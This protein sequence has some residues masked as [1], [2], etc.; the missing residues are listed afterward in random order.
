MQIDLTL[1]ETGLQIDSFRLSNF[2][3]VLEGSGM[4]MEGP[5]LADWM[6]GEESWDTGQMELD[7]SLQ[8]PSLTWRLGGNPFRITGRIDLAG[9]DYPTFSFFLNARD[10]LLLRNEEANAR[11][12]LELTFKG[13]LPQMSLSGHITLTEGQILSRLRFLEAWIDPETRLSGPAIPLFSI[14]DPWLKDMTFDVRI[15]SYRPFKVRNNVLRSDMRPSLIL[16]GTGALPT[17]SGQIYLE[18]SVLF[19]PSSRILIHSGVIEFPKENPDQAYLDLQ[20]RTTMYGYDTTIAI[21][22]PHQD[23][24]ITVSSTP[25]LS[26]DEILLMLFTGLP[27]PRISARNSPGHPG[28]RVAVYVVRD[29]MSRWLRDTSPSQE[30]PFL[31]RF[32]LSIGGKVTRSGD[33]TIDA[34]YLLKEGLLRQADAFYVTLEKDIYDHHNVGL[35]LM[36]RFR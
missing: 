11:A 30:N 13:T 20:G 19:L 29:V 12:D 7:L 10:F 25:V 14:E 34:R 1:R 21:Q 18:P 36:F 9:P 3:L 15:G 23:P 22:G 4:W 33:E 28:S 24:E 5:T 17:L 31:D 8:S 2:H 26:S 32:D 16:G 6:E 27:P 35:R